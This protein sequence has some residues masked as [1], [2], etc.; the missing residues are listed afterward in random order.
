MPIQP[1]QYKRVASLKTVEEFKAYLDELGI[2]L[3]LDSEILSGDA[4][5]LSDS[6]SVGDFTIGNRF[7]IHPME[8]W[9]GTEDGR[10]TE[11][12]RRRWRN[13]GTSGAKLIWGCEAVAVRLDG[14]ANPNQLCLYEE[15][16]DDFASL[17]EELVNVHKERF[18]NT[19]DLLV[20]LQL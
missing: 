20:G 11:Y 19:D 12:V 9:D 3:P 6:I 5:P 1:G 14:R 8:G 16:K 17:R 10:P 4:S 15:N 2:S 18:G 7:C 13:F